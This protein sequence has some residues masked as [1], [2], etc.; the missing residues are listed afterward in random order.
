MTV[1]T[2]IARDYFAEQVREIPAFRALIRAIECTIFEDIGD[3]AEPLLDLG[4]GDGHFAEHAYRRPPTIGI[5]VTESNV[6]QARRRNAYQSLAV[7]DASRMPFADG[8][9]ATVTSNCVI[10]HIPDVEAAMAEVSR[11]LQPGGRLIFGVPSHRFSQMLLAP[12]LLR[13]ASLVGPARAYANWFNRISIH[14]TTDSPQAWQDR[15]A[16]HGFAVERW[17]YYMSPAA[18]RAFDVA[19]YLGV[20]R[21]ISYKLTGKWMLFPNPIADAFFRAWLGKYARER[22]VPVGACIFFQARK[23]EGA[24][25]AA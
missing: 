11:V 16:R 3:L 15:L 24:R 5:D 10:E 20:P 7:A 4:C 25:N 1:H 23:V 19:H 17:Q 8:A 21:L 22:N 2:R 18:T 12:T 13:R 9:F 14:F 6:R